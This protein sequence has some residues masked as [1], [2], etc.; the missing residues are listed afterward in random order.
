MKERPI[1]MSAPMVRALLAGMKTQ[2]RRVVKPQPPRDCE[3]VYAPF[4]K[5]P[6][7]WQGV[8]A[9]DLIGWYGRCPYG[10]P[11]DRL[12]AR[13]TWTGADDPAHKHAVHYRADGERACRWRPSIFMPRWASRLMLEVVNVRVERVQEINE[14][15]A[16]AEGV[17]FVKEHSPDHRRYAAPAG[18]ET[19]STAHDAFA[20]VWHRLNAKRGYGWDKNPWV[21]CLTFKRVS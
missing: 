5:D 19:W 15:D 1:L 18:Q 14:P 2:T 12:W 4:A 21:W 3:S 20:W 16:I 11:G 7:N 6:N 17:Q 13:E 8:C 9:D 10:V